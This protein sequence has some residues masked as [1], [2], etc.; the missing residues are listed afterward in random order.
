ML[1]KTQRNIHTDKNNIVN[2]DKKK[3]S[4]RWNCMKYSRIDVNYTLFMRLYRAISFTHLAQDSLN[5]LKYSTTIIFS[6]NLVV[7]NIVQKIH[8]MLVH[9]L[10]QKLGRKSTYTYLATP[11]I[12]YFTFCHI[13]YKY[14]VLFCGH[15]EQLLSTLWDLPSKK[16]T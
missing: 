2:F 13:K 8:D 5:F 1:Q 14:T 12:E 10:V 11:V 4:S 9:Y 3:L 6:N 16:L 15:T 7:H